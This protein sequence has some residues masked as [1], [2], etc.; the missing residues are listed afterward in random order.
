MDGVDQ[1]TRSRAR[2]TV[3]KIAMCKNA[4]GQTKKFKLKNWRKAIGLAKLGRE[5]A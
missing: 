2:G 4:G 5:K 3:T 1:P